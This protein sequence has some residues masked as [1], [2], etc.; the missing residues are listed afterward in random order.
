M[1]PKQSVAPLWHLCS[2]VL[3][4]V[5]RRAGHEVRLLGI[6]AARMHRLVVATAEETRL[7]Y[8]SDQEAHR[9]WMSIKL[10]GHLGKFVL[11]SEESSSYKYSPNRS[12]RDRTGD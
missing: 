12:S 9:T 8:P 6:V 4:E 5:N 7:K 2:V 1:Q 3:D 11:G 10:L